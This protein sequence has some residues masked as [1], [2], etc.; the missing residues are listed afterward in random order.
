MN[1]FPFTII[2]GL[3]CPAA[4]L[5]PAA[6]AGQKP[7]VLFLL[8]DELNGWVSWLGGHPQSRKPRIDHFAARGM[9][10]AGAQVH[11]L[12]QANR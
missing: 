4:A 2:F 1:S 10:G 9:L 3:S 12:Q 7:D 8:I 5:A 11:S 6:S